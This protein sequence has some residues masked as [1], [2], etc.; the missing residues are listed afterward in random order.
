MMTDSRRPVNPATSQNKTKKPPP[1]YKTWP[2]K[3]NTIQ[4]TIAEA[5]RNVYPEL[6][7][8]FCQKQK[9]AEVMGSRTREEVHRLPVE[10][11]SE[12][13]E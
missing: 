8:S 6:E 10:C 5:T 2:K 13:E 12:G 11:D 1:P 7:E 3:P 4:D 9:S